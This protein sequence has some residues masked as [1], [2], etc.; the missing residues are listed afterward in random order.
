LSTTEAYD[1]A[2]HYDRVMAAWQ[3]LLGDELHYGVFDA[4]DE[5]LSV[6]TGALTERMIAAAD[7]GAG[8]PL[9]VL[10]V[11]CGSGAPA[12]ALA[13]RFGVEV[14]GI[15]TSGVGVETARLRTAEAGVEGVTFEQRDGTDNGFDDA[16]FD[17][18]WVMESAHLM[19]DKDALV[20]ECA[21]VL[22]PGGR[23][24]LCDLIRWREIPFREVRD[25]RVDFA[26]LREAFG[27]AHFQSLDDYEAL[28]GAHGLVVDRSDDL[29]SA[30]LPT[31]DR[32]RANAD[33]HRDAVVDLIGVD[34]HQAF[35]RSCD[36]LEAFWRDG[37]FG[38]G[39]VS[40][41]KPE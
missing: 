35:V 34:G 29:T 37:T 15:T 18:A 8:A 9:R 1:P 4:G 17:R 5:P 24:V 26:V 40:A 27:D 10:D 16:T 39:L 28:A 22:R 3:L 11:G 2:S 31:F 32:W 13:T 25:R 19:R 36:I 23:L 30:T 41:T 33:A 38:Y 7:L 6:A 12:R 20:S 14:V 21:R